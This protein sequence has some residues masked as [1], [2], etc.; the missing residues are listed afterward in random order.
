MKEFV[1][2]LVRDAVGK[3]ASTEIPDFDEICSGLGLDVK[4]DLLSPGVDGI[5]Q[6]RT[7]LINSRIQSEERKQFTRFHEV[8]H[9]LINED[10]ELISILHDATWSQNGEY[11]KQLERLCNVGTAEFLMPREEL[12]KLYKEQGFNVE[13]ISFAA[14]HFKSS[15]IAATVQLAQ[16]A[17]NSCIT[18]IC[19]YGLLP[20]ETAQSQSDLFDEENRTPKPKLH[21]VYSASSPATKYWLARGTNIPDAHLINQ[22]FLEAQHLE[23]ESH[24]PFRSGNQMPCD[25]EALPDKDRVYVLFHLTPPPNPNPDQLTFI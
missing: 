21:V 12:T 16:V 19:E 17:P 25:C 9:Y 20:N 23:G 24:V 15:T 14:N 5:L 18:A 1:I 2:K 6:G 22:A 10:G 3:Y 7:I 11:K 13:L 4:E 8:V